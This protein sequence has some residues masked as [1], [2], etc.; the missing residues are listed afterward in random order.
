MN[1]LRKVLLVSL[2]SLPLAACSQPATNAPAQTPSKTE[3]AVPTVRLN[4]ALPDFTGLVE[5]EG[6]AVVNISTT[7]KIRERGAPF[8]QFRDLPEEDPF[9]E[10]FKRFMPQQPHGGRGAPRE[11]ETHSLGSG[12]IISPDGYILT[13]AHVVDNADEVVVKITDKREFKAKVIGADRRTDVALL[14]IDAKSLPVAN[15]GDPN[16][17]KVG[18]WVVAIGSPYGFENSVTA[19]IV[20]AKGRALPGDNFVSFIQTDVAVN[21]GNSGGPLFNL[22]GEVVGVNSQIY[23]RT[24]GYMGLSFA[25]PIDVAMDIVSQLKGNGKVS[26][27]RMGIQIQEVTPE[28]AASFGLKDA[29]GAL[30]AAIEKGSPAE[31][32][33]M[34]PGDVILKFEGKVVPSSSDLPRMVGATKPGSKTKLEVWRNG[35]SK[36]LSITLAEWDE[37]KVAAVASAP[38]AEKANRLGLT[39]AEINAEDKRKL[40]LENGLLVENVSGAAEKAGLRRGD[41][42]L[43]L[44]GEKIVSLAQFAKLLDQFKNGK[45]IA[46]LIRRG[47]QILFVPVDWGK[48]GK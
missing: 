31:K 25:I 3:A 42:V 33:G 44:G 43:S 24:G 38:K 36:D 27:G 18:E 48:D 19:G 8:P 32:A 10:F 9:Y 35:S 6:P 20:S 16:K 47:E 4:G 40:N 13:N 26:R 7:Q 28:L 34:Q 46:L 21:P 39:L 45:T 5:K 17:M 37:P 22:R 2:L 41:I 29:K 12:F 30:V 15:L 14:K 11:Y 23:S 1:F